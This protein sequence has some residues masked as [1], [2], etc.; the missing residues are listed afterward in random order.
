MAAALGKELD[1]LGVRGGREIYFLPN[2]LL[3]SWNVLSVPNSFKI[4][5][6]AELV[7][8]WEHS[9]ARMLSGEDGILKA[10]KE[11]WEAYTQGSCFCV[12]GL[13]KLCFLL[14]PFLISHLLL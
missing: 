4:I 7:I 9:Y 13:W 11:G 1:D 12:L 5:S 8:T 10:Q 3:Y 2:P 14:S 6:Y